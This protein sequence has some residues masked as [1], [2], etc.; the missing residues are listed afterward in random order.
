MSTNQNSKV[1]VNDEV[2]EQL[3]ALMFRFR[4]EMR[5]MVHEAGHPVNGMEVR[6]LSQIA[7]NPGC[8]AMELARENHRDKAQIA[9]VIQQLEQY[10]LASRAPDE[11]D[12]RQQR[13]TL[14]DAGKELASAL[15]R[16]RQSVGRKLLAALNAEE[17]RQLGQLL[18]KLRIE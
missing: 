4:A 13:L 10:G 12:R 7:R 5:R 18:A 15:H 6:M 3:S 14:T 8:T 9:R 17:Q 16:T 2:L 1:S 11:Q